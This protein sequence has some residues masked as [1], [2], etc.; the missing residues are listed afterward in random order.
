MDYLLSLVPIWVWLIV[1][2]ALAVAAYFH[3]GWKG[4]LVAV[5]SILAVFGYGKGR[6]DATRQ[7]DAR[8]D[9]IER[10]REDAY[11]QIDNRGTTKSDAAERLRKGDY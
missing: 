8:A 1:A 3:F 9:N 2:V 6:R 11:A 4:L 10:K 7:H 5:A